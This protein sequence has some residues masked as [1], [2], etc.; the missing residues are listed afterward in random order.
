[1]KS[2]FQ[3]SLTKGV[4][5]LDGDNLAPFLAAVTVSFLKEPEKFSLVSAHAYIGARAIKRP[6]DLGSDIVICKPFSNSYHVS[7]IDWQRW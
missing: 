3:G 4:K 2:T 5:H 6:L 7:I 1:M